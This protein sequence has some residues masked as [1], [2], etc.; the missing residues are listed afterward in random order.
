SLGVA[1]SLNDLAV[2]LYIQGKAA[3]AEGT[4]REALAIQV[5]IY[6]AGHPYVLNSLYN[7]VRSISLQ[8]NL[9]AAQLQDKF[10][11]TEPVARQCQTALTEKYPDDWISF[12][13][14]CLLGYCL[15]GQK[16]YAEAEP[17]LLSGLDGLKQ[18]E[19]KVP[20][21]DKPRLIDAVSALAKLYEATS[22]P[23]PA[24]QW[25]TTLADLKKADQ[26]K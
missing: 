18:R 21:G 19:D 2:D 26:V 12:S 6:G 4:Q 14:R 10:A 16:K 23:D 8:T 1:T 5:K 17:L 25:K 7:L 15:V 13:G 3:E 24:A 20:A 11:E 22:R 9:T